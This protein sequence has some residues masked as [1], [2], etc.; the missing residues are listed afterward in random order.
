MPVNKEYEL[1]LSLSQ[2]IDAQEM[3][4]FNSVLTTLKNNAQNS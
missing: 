3:E 4:T 1:F 2:N